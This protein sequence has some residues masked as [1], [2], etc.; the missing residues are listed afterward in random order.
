M[1]MR[2]FATPQD[3]EAAFYDALERAD[4]DAMMAIWA[5]DE[6]VTCT[7][8]GGER[9]AGFAAVR[10]G[11]RQTFASLQRV[12]VRVSEVVHR[13]GILLALSSVYEHYSVRGEAAPRPPVI[14]SNVYVR[15][16]QGWHL[17]SRHASAAPDSVGAD[18][19]ATLH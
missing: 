18:S 2:F 17:L 13:Q 3:A 16:A 12:G 1:T 11:W 8:L 6:E 7:H 10:E 9:L 15:G 4:L 5:E 14:A 19:S